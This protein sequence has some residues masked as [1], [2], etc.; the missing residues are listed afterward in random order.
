MKVLF[1]VIN[2][3]LRRAGDTMLPEHVCRCCKDVLSGLNRKIAEET[4]SLLEIIVGM[5]ILFESSHAAV[6]M[7]VKP[8]MAS[9]TVQV[10]LNSDPA[11]GLPDRL[12]ETKMAFSGTT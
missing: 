5:G 6:G 2:T 1:V 9:D 10:R 11:T 3:G 8:E 7:S 4:L 12:M